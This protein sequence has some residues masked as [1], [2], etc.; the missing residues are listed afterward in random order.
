MKTWLTETFGIKLPIIMAPMFLV[1]NV[2]MLKA[3]ADA[4]IM[5]CIPAL[6]WREIEDFENG[7][8]DL[9]ESESIYKSLSTILLS[10]SF[11]ICFWRLCF[12]LS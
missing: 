2:E 10:F 1:S 8:K 7:L 6:N 11:G 5:G 9:K 3:A 4:G 12:W